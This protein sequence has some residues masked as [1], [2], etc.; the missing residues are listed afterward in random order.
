MQRDQ[1]SNFAAGPS[2]LP[3]S[4]L[5]KIQSELLNYNGTGMSVMELSHRSPTFE[6][7]LETTKTNLRTLLSIPNNYE[8]LFMQGVVPRN[9]VPFR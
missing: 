5:Q 2:M 6:T 7:I 3:T 4:V 9:L 8:I 1:I